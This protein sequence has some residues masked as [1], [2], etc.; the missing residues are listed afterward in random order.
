M[1]VSCDMISLEDCYRGFR[2]HHRAETEPVRLATCSSLFAWSQ[3]LKILVLF[4]LSFATSR[5]RRRNWQRGKSPGDGRWPP[6]DGAD[7]R[8]QES[9]SR[10][11]CPVR[12]QHRRRVGH[13][14]GP[15]RLALRCPLAGNADDWSP[16]GEK[17][18]VGLGLMVSASAA[19]IA[20]GVHVA[21]GRGR[22][23]TPRSRPC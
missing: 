4:V 11:R 14:P 16:N 20:L 2:L 21:S 6:G 17:A 23:A 15:P 19:T 1:G 8:G 22:R 9:A 13:L 3:R 5:S 10:S 7:L 18:F 12:M